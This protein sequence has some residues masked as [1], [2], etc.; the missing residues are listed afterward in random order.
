M[1]P[2][3]SVTRSGSAA[4]TRAH[5][6]A[7]VEGHAPTSSLTTCSMASMDVVPPARPP[8]SYSPTT[9]SS[10]PQTASAAQPVPGMS[11]SSGPRCASSATTASAVEARPRNCLVALTAA[12]RLS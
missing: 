7:L 4:R 3:D 6:V 2:N 8:R 5:A 12:H 11:S 10:A 9:A 1:E